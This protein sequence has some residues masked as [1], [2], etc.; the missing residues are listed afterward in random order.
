MKKLLYILL[1][2]I[3]ALTVT[4]SPTEGD[5]CSGRWPAIQPI[6]KSYHFV[7][8][9]NMVVKLQILGVD[10][11]PFLY[12]LECYLNAYDYVFG[13]RNFDYSGDFECRLTSLYS[14]AAQYRTLLFEDKNAN[15]DWFSRGVF[16]TEELS[17]ECAKYPEWGRIRHFRLRGMKLTLE[18]KNFQIELGSK[19][20]NA[21]WGRDRVKELDLEVT[22]AS[23]PTAKSEIAE[24]VG[25]ARPPLSTDC[26]WSWPAIKPIKKRVHFTDH[27]GAKLQIMGVDG[28]PLYLLECH[29][30][31][32]D[33]LY[34]KDPSF[35]YSGVLDCRLTPVHPEAVG[36][37]TLLTE[38]THQTSDTTRARFS[39]RELF[40][41]CAD[42]PEWG[43]VRH[44]RLR[45]MVLTLEVK[46]IQM[47]P[48]GDDI[49]G[50]DLKVTVTS[51]PTA[52]AEIAEP[53]KYAYPPLIHPDDVN[54]HS[55]NCENVL[56]K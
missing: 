19:N 5:E 37:S 50:L 33:E 29:L 20:E 17:G 30:K 55:R 27:E 21:P 56:V 28:N 10:G 49:E 15:R 53:T 40:G 48:N 26:K 18:V 36:Y 25:L 2:Q 23:D 4:G 13:Y 24:P 35:N 12:L 42:Y 47:T 41:K 31:P 38:E 44:F 16:L 3:V 39:S 14:E 51:D 22:V 11:T 7:D 34:D 52:I 9:S 1:V 8:H 43:R 45:G 46:D 32:L 54:N 6:K